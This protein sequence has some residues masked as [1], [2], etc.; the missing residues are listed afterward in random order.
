MQHL[1]NNQLKAEEIT[2]IHIQRKEKMLILKSLK[3]IKKMQN[4]VQVVVLWVVHKAEI[5]GK[6]KV[7]EK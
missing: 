5:L 6:K 7:K 3:E 2:T 4:Q 1:I